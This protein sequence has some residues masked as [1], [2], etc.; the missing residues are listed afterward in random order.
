MS[1]IPMSTTDIR[2]D[3]VGGCRRVPASGA[4]QRRLSD[5][6]AEGSARRRSGETDELPRPTR[7]FGNCRLLDG[8]S[9]GYSMGKGFYAITP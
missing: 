9:I 1:T 7:L 3:V 4:V 5:P 6:M 2:T 8:W